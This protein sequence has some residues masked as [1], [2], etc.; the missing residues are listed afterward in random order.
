M[1]EII[2]EYPKMKKEEE[3]EKRFYRKISLMI[4]FILLYFTVGMVILLLYFFNISIPPILNNGKSDYP[5]TKS[6]MDEV[7]DGIHTGT[8]LKYDAHIVLIQKHC[9][10]CHSSA[11]ILQNKGDKERWKNIIVWMQE[12]QN[13]WDLGDDEPGILEYLSSHYKAEFT[14]RRQGIDISSIEWYDIP[15]EGM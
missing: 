11:I 9:L 15:A 4:R 2:Y 8:G 10:S 5:V 1:S 12:K 13:L 14:G 7:V 3:A 6:E